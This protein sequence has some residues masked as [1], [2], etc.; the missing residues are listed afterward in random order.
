MALDNNRRREKLRF[1]CWHR[2]TREMDLLLGRFADRYV[3]RFEDAELDE[4]EALLKTSDP[5]LYR[6]ITG[7]EVAPDEHRGTVLDLLLKFKYTE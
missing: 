3:A 7:A 6:W 5:D 2:G 4:L 1:R